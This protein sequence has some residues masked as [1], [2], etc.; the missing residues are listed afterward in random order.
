MFF[1]K[2]YEA[3]E[4]GQ[5]EQR[6]TPAEK[7]AYW[8]NAPKPSEQGTNPF[9]EMAKLRSDVKKHK[10]EQKAQQMAL[11]ENTEGEPE[12]AWYKDD[13]QEKLMDYHHR[14]S[15]TK[16]YRDDRGFSV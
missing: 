14:Y 1:R 8:N 10:E 16:K 3:K 2:F 15:E 11:E 12:D 13:F 5:F 4:R 7:P 9:L 6:E